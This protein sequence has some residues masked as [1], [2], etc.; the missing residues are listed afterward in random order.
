M[1]NPFAWDAPWFVVACG[2]FV[3]VMLRAN[4]TYWLG[5]GVAHQTARTRWSSLLDSPGYHQAC[6]WIERWGAPVVTVSFLTVG[7]QTLVNLSA[8]AT[9]MPLRRYLPAVIIGC[10]LW[11]VLYATVGMVGFR[12]FVALHTWSPLVAWALVIVGIAT[13]AVVVVARTRAA[14]RG[15]TDTVQDSREQVAPNRGAAA[16]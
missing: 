16:P 4:A 7:V 12:A 1:L 5:R 13:L 11:A 2:L 8:G 14:R 3:V 15:R 6:R 10:M 9:R